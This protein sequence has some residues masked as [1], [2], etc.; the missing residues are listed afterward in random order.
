MGR[1]GR[2]GLDGCM[3]RPGYGG[4]AKPRHVLRRFPGDPR[5]LAVAAALGGLD[6]VAGED[7]QRRGEEEPEG[8]GAGVVGMG[9][10]EQTVADRV[11]RRGG[12]LTQGTAIGGEAP[13]GAAATRGAA[14]LRRRRPL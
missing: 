5:R 7:D 9:V 13:D 3:G 14:R 1:L 8:G 2:N 11:E 12:D 4:D 10:V 6:Q